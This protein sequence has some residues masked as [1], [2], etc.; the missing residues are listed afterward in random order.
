MNILVIK[1]YNNHQ[2][3]LIIAIECYSEGKK[4]I[5]FKIIDSQTYK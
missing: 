4:G 5:S 3:M 1:K 2:D